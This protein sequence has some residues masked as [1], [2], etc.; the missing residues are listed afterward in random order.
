MRAIH[1]ARA[2]RTQYGLEATDVAPAGRLPVDD[3]RT[4]RAVATRLNAARAAGRAAG[5]PTVTGGE[6]AALATLHEIYHHVLRTQAGAAL[7]DA[8]SSA[9]AGGTA[10]LEA[11]ARAAETKAGKR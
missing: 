3:L 9:P 6:L 8:A 10:A 1:L 4:A 2:A 11:A 7:T 5:P